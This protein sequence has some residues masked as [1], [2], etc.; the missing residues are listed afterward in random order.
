MFLKFLYNCKANLFSEV[1]VNVIVECILSAAY[2]NP[3]S[4][5][6]F[7]YVYLILIIAYFYQFELNL[8]LVNDRNQLLKITNFGYEKQKKAK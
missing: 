5:S 7:T 1:P 6:P 8:L 3:I 4:K 2:R